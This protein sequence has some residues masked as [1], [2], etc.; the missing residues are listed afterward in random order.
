MAE[1]RAQY[2]MNGDIMMLCNTLIYGGRLRCGNAAVASAQLD[3]PRFPAA[4]RTPT[5]L[6]AFAS[7]AAAA[8]AA[9]GAGA[10]AG[11][12]GAAGGRPFEPP[13]PP[14]WLEHALDPA[15]S[16]AF[17]DTDRLIPEQP[18]LQTRRGERGGVPSASGGG[19]LLGYGAEEDGGGA[20]AGGAAGAK[21][22]A[23]P[24]APADPSGCRGPEGAAPSGPT[25]NEVEA[26]LVCDLAC[27]LLRCGLLP[28]ELGVASPYRAQLA[29]V[30]E[31]LRRTLRRAGLPGARPGE[32]ARDLCARVEVKTVDKYQGRDKACLLVTTVHSNAAGEVGLLLEDRRRINVLLSRAKHKLLLVGSA[33][34]LATAKSSAPAPRGPRPPLSNPKPPI[35]SELMRVLLGRKWV[36]GLPAGAHQGLI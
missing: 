28:E 2:R 7:H 34:T 3:L 11:S 27:W 9:A 10:A 12:R 24:G 35:S 15:V 1:L 26:Q 16:V 19:G 14:A 6:A 29:L 36:V 23:A 4:L 20:R 32:S 13:R 17:L 5:A 30:S 8:E 18:F 33:S 22:A 25:V 21:A 31:T